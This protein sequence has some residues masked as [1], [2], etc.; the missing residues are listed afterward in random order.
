LVRDSQDNVRDGALVWDMLTRD[1]LDVSSG[2]FFYHVDAG[3]LGESW[4]N[5]DY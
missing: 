3:E 1:R 5:C 4:K 2:I